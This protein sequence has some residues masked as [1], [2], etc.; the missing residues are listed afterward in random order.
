MPRGRR[1]RPAPPLPPKGF[2]QARV[3]LL[4]LLAEHE[5]TPTEFALIHALAAF[6]WRGEGVDVTVSELGR[7][8]GVTRVHASN[9]LNRLM[10][11]GLVTRDGDGRLRLNLEGGINVNSNLRK[12]GSLPPTPPIGGG[13][14]YSPNVGDISLSERYLPDRAREEKPPPPNL[15]NTNTSD[16]RK[17]QFTQNAIYANSAL[18][19]FGEQSIPPPL[20][21]VFALLNVATSEGM[22]VLAQ[23]GVGPRALMAWHKER[24]EGS[25]S[26]VGSMITLARK[27]PDLARRQAKRVLAS[28]WHSW[29]GEDFCPRCGAEFQT[30]GY[31]PS[32]CPSCG[33]QLRV[34]RECHELAVVGEPCPYCGAPDLEFDEDEGDMVVNEGVGGETL[35]STPEEVVRDVLARAH[36]D[37]RGVEVLEIE[38]GYLVVVPT[39]MAEMMLKVENERIVTAL[40]GIRGKDVRVEYVVRGSAEHVRI[41]KMLEE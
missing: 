30:H 1:R 33:V 14:N 28:K 6:D 26:N 7:R 8:I 9:M 19:E 37:D 4:E 36:V 39:A 34:C 3:V 2:Y 17:L 11:L 10:Q 35:P 16:L 5:I 24:Q 12:M 20:Q 21:G 31:P 13:D 25:G 32:E 27:N 29:W 18:Q 41:M 38:D 40:Q 23:L 22:S 15:S